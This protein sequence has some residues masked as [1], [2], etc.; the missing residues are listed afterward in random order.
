MKLPVLK[1]QNLLLN[2][3]T[4]NDLEDFLVH[5]N[6]AEDFSKNLFNIAF[7]YTKEEAKNWLKICD[8]GYETGNAYRFAIREIEVGKLIGIIAIHM[9]KDHQKG[10]LGY[11]LGKN[12]WGKGYL[13]ESV[14]EIL[15]FGFQEL[16]LNKIFA[17]HFLHNPASEKVMQKAGMKLEGL[18]KQ[19]YFHQGK[20]LDVNRYA[21]LKEDFS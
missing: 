7:P 21:I 14:K 3:P 5:I 1:T 11:W 9:N 4:E 16:Q 12:F 6:S 19:E 13:T 8:E 20:F 15:K 2:R 10:E 17:T 18:Q